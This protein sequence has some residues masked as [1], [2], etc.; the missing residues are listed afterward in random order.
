MS[1]V[2]FK[3]HGI[4]LAV[5]LV[6]DDSVDI[7]V[8]CPRGGLIR[9]GRV[10]ARGDGS[11]P[12]VERARVLPPYSSIIVFEDDS[13]N[14]KGHEITIGDVAYRILTVDEVL[15]AIIPSTRR[16]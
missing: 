4:H 3:V 1:R 5:R 16:G 6:P 14:A 7:K 9:Y 12:R 8:V 13:E 11:D 2:R 10:V 15:L